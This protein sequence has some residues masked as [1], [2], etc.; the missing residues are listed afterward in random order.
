MATTCSD[1]RYLSLC[2]IAPRGNRDGYGG[3]NAKLYLPFHGYVF[4]SGQ[5][6]T[7]VGSTIAQ[8]QSRFI[9]GISKPDTFRK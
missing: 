5:T 8:D 7:P 6:F 9:G 1:Q 2:R 4:A 3:E